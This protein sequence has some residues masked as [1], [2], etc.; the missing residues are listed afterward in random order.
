MN[1]TF[2]TSLEF[3]RNRTF[4]EIVVGDRASIQRTLTAA[5]LQL[6]AAMS[7]DLARGAGHRR[8]STRPPGSSRTGCGAPP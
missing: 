4:D 3:L 1:S 6:L 8:E 2:A 7:G 5:D